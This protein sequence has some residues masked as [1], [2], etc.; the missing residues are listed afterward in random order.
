MSVTLRP[1][2]AADQKP[3]KDLIHLV[4]INPTS[5]NWERFIVA[6]EAGQFVG[7]VQLKPHNDGVIELASLAVQPTYQGKG[8]GGQLIRALLERHPGELYLICRSTL[9]SYYARFGF[10]LVEVQDLPDSFKMQ[11]R[12]GR[13]LAR[14]SKFPGLSIMRRAGAGEP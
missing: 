8:V 4:G 9:A 11:H 1:A 7:C 5:L 3:I 6:E 12:F 2:T 14:I 10:Q 13:L